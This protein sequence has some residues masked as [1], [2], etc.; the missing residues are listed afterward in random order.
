MGRMVQKRVAQRFVSLQLFDPPSKGR[1]S[2]RLIC[3]SFLRICVYN[4]LFLTPCKKE[5]SPGYIYLI[6]ELFL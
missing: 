1:K 5:S 6:C 4:V 2:R 3:K